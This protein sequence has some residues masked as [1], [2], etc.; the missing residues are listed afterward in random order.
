MCP[1][2]G[3]DSGAF[4]AAGDRRACLTP[5][6]GREVEVEQFRNA[7]DRPAPAR[8]RW[9]RSSASRAWASRRLVFECLHSLLTHSWLVLETAQCR[10]ARRRRTCRRATCSDLPADHRCDDTQAI[11]AKIAASSLALD[12]AAEGCDA[13]PA[14][15]ARGVAGG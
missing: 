11:R 3:R 15:A 9:W 8:A 12:E 13:G 6:V 14:V 4:P 10:T 5:F 7:L 1:G 2:H